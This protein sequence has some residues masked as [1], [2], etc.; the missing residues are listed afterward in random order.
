M[1]MQFKREVVTP[2]VAARYLERTRPID[3]RQRSVS[4]VS[5]YARAMLDGRFDAQ[6]GETIKFDTTGS[7][8]DGQHRLAAIVKSGVTLTLSVI[9]NLSPEA[10]FT[11]D[12]GKGRTKKDILK[13]SGFNLSTS[14]MAGVLSS[15]VGKGV[16]GAV[17]REAVVDLAKK[18]ESPLTFI[19]DTFTRN[20]VSVTTA[21]VKAV[22][23][24]AFYTEDQNRLRQFAEVLQ[25]GIP[26]S[27]DDIP[28]VMLRN[29]LLVNKQARSGT[30][31]LDVYQ[32][33]ER[34]LRAFL[35]REHLTKLFRAKE[36]QFQIPE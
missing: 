1:D 2:E 8:V 10:K 20:V 12:S 19:L 34:A 33:T 30:Q 14:A 23:A 22:V 3:Q 9:R 27:K 35:D 6:N 5:K 24:R 28:A 16:I 11:M 13:Y 18:H 7:L 17:P 15:M 4:T 21:P 32:R 29:W 36:E 25:S 31:V 26:E